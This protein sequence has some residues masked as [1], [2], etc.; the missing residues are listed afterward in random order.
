MKADAGPTDLLAAGWKAP[1]RTS[2]SSQEGQER[3]TGPAGKGTAPQMATW[4]KLSPV[5]LHRAGEGISTRFC[6]ISWCLY[7]EGDLR[8]AAFSPRGRQQGGY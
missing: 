7:P 8:L 5:S 3:L 4:A 1:A 6:F 2:N